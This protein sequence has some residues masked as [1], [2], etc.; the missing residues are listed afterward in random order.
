MQTMNLAL[1]ILDL[2][3]KINYSPIK[4]EWNLSYKQQSDEQLE[5]SSLFDYRERQNKGS[6]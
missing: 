4:N 2:L 1:W 5:A 3:S 6:T